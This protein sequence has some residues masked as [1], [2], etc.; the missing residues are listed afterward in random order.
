MWRTTVLGGIGGGVACAEGLGCDG[1]VGCAD[2][3]VESACALEDPTAGGLL[4]A[5][6]VVLAAAEAEGA[7]R[8]LA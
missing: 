5:P 8:V 3:A 1:G 7:G 6:G 2:G 4:G